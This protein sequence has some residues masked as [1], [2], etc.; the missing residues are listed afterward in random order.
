MKTC[1]SEIKSRYPDLTRVEKKIADFILQYYDEVIT[2]SV[3]EFAQKAEVAQSA[4]VRCCKS[5]GFDGYSDFKMSLAMELSRNK[6]LNFVPYISP[7]DTPGAVMD[8]VF[9][10][11]VKTLHDTAERLDREMLENVV[12]LLAGAEKIY[13]YAVGTSAG[14]A[15]DFQ[16]RLMQFGFCAFCVT[17]VPTM[18]IST[19]NITPG[20]V[21]I[22]ISHSGRSIATV[23]TLR[24][25]KERGAGTVCLTSYPKSIITENCDYPI[26]VYSD[27]INYP[28]EAVSARIC[29]MSVLDS[30]SIS[31]SAANYEN[32]LRR[33]KENRDLIDTIRYEE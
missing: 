23:E 15:V 11:N 21:A 25:A 18:K 5:L 33:A 31:L 27:E 29:H 20:D 24:L 32:T 30:I 3:G 17:D 2:L 19:L 12:R 4:V 6:Q 26:C 1:I 28:V 10:A 13:I 22:G 16:Y 7:D 9:G 8:K 14:L